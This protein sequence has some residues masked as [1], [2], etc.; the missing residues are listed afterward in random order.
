MGKSNGLAAGEVG[1]DIGAVHIGL[2]LVVDEN[3]DDVGL[4]GSLGGCHDGKAVLLGDSPAFSALVKADDDVAAGIAQV[5]GMGMALGAIADNG[6]LL[7]LQITELA[8]FFIVKFCHN[9][10]LLFII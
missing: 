9:Q 3:H 4:L 7:P 10:T 1:G 8:V 2:L 5:H 6:D